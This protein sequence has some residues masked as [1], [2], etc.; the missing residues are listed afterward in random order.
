[1][2]GFFSLA[3]LLLVVALL[4]VVPPLLG[5]RLR[6]GDVS[7][8]ATNLSIYKDQLKELDADLANGV[9]DKDQY[10]TAKL[11]IERRVIEEVADDVDSGGARVVPQWTLAVVVAV[12]VPLV[13]ISTYLAV[14]SPEAF[15]AKKMTAQGSE[16]GHDLTPERIAQMIDQVKDR[17]KNNPEDIESWVMLAKAAQAIGR[18]D[19]AVT[20]YRELVKRLPPDAQLLADFADTLAIANGRSLDGEP[21]RLIEQALSVDPNNTK[22]LALAG[23]IA[24]Q[25]QDYSRAAQYWRRILNGIPPESEFAQ[26]IQGSIREAEQMAGAESGTTALVKNKP[27][28]S[29]KDVSIQGTVV[30]APAIGKSASA[31]DTVFIFARAKSGP[32][33]P[34]AVQR[35]QVGQLPFNF[36]LTEAMAMTPE[37]TLS[38]FPELVV[39]ARVSKSG[40]A[41][42]QAGDLESELVP[43]VVGAKNIRIIINKEVK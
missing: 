34:L 19:D 41:V 12:A 32:K 5:K 4:F 1:M 17:L 7:H 11:E 42:P 40:N 15:D 35:V 13:A 30:I 39:G 16:G 23:T 22:A 27:A 20:A 21:Q 18:Y 43:V 26:R 9:L 25:K 37:M 8:R 33:M 10:E 14:G 24:F 2:I 36:E 31:G 3:A 28:K 38:K 6:L 29:L